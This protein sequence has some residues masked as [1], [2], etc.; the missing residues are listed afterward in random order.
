MKVKN[1]PFLDTIQKKIK[2][3]DPFLSEWCSQYYHSQKYRL[4]EELVL[5]DELINKNSKVLELGSIPPFFTLALKEKGVDITGV[6]IAP[7]RFSVCIR[8]LGLDIKTCNFEWE[9]LP[10]ADNF[11]QVVILNEIFEHLRIDLIFS[12]KEI[13][14]IMDS[15]AILMLST[16]N[17]LSLRRMYHLITKKEVLG[18]EI[19]PEFEKLHTLGHMG[20]LRIYTPTEVSKFLEK[21]GFKVK[22]IIYRQ[23]APVDNKIEKFF[24]GVIP[25]LRHLFTIV[26]EKLENQ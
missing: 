17:F 15:G 5:C 2:V 24:Y 13:Y 14:R 6:D 22:K 16:P 7:E 10:F 19:Y 1:L 4:S 23:P 3:D 25:S 26:V 12:L 20:H 8:D 18:C 11:F 21:I 9:K